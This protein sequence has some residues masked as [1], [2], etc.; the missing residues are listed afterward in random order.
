MTINHEAVARSFSPNIVGLILMPT[1]QCCFRC[2]Y[3]YEDFSL[4][5]MPREVRNGIVNL[6]KSRADHL[7]YLT[8]SW[9]GGEPLMAKEVIYD[10]SSQIVELSKQKAIN[11]SASMTT[12]A[13][14]LDTECFAKLIHLG[15]NFFQ[16]TL[17]GPK[18]IH[19]LTRK[20]VDGKGTFDSIMHNLKA[21]KQTPYPFTIS[22]RLHYKPDTWMYIFPLLDE[23]KRELLDDPR[24]TVV[25]HAIGKWGGANDK[26]Y[27]VFDDKLDQT[28]IEKKLLTHLLGEH[29]SEEAVNEAG[30]IC[31]AAKANHIV[32][33][34]NGN[35]AK[36][37]VALSHPNND[38]G[39]LN[40][41]G[42]L[43]IY[44]E[45]YKKWLIGFQTGQQD[46]LACPAGSALQEPLGTLK[47][48]PII[49]AA[50]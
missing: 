16:I 1:E 42:T 47:S 30:Y 5:K 22:L 26:S 17:D 48:I 9:F 14:L 23:L 2:S 35:L 32:I 21:I 41:D 24:F 38:V 11:Y 31:Y 37:T 36:C 19:D 28:T 10:L 34:A 25:F 8:I 39:H 33:R 15:V 12:N 7:D 6:L 27:E 18:A 4:G 13:Y 49:T 29:K 40:P 43:A 44:Q 45:R 46:Q 3:C 20:R 50:A